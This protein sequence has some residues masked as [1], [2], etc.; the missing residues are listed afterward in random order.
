MVGY[1]EGTG[2]DSDLLLL[3]EHD[4]K[5]HRAVFQKQGPQLTRPGGKTYP[6]ILFGTAENGKAEYGDS[7]SC[8]YLSGAQVRF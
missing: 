4:C 6:A 3:S 2:E 1:C 8:S 5:R 7:L